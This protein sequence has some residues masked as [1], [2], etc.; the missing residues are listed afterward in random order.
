MNDHILRNHAYA[1]TMTI[2]TMVEAMGMQA[3]N[4]HRLSR[5]ESIAYTEQAF[6]DLV[7]KNGCHHNSVLSLD[8]SSY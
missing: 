2:E 7:N 3:E 8:W 4:Q 5:G 6:V 1:I